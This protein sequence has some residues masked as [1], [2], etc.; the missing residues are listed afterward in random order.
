MS[1][2]PAE[3]YQLESLHSAEVDAGKPP[4]PSPSTASIDPSQVRWLENQRSRKWEVCKIMFRACGTLFSAIVLGICLA[5]YSYRPN[6]VLDVWPGILLFGAVP[7]FFWDL[8]EFLTLCARYGRGITP[9]ALIGLELVLSVVSAVAAGYV[10]LQLSWL[11]GDPA[12]NPVNLALCACVLTGINATNTLSRFI[13]FCLFIRACIERSREIRRRRPR[14]MYI[15]ETGQTVYVVAKP[16]PKLPTWQSQNSARAPSFP[17]SPVQPSSPLGTTEPVTSTFPDFT[18]SPRPDTPPPPLP[19]RPGHQHALPSAIKRKPV[20][21]LPPRTT[22]GDRDRH[23]RPSMR[24][25]PD[26]YVPDEAE[27]ERMRRGD[28]QPQLIL[29]G[30]VDLKFATGAN[31]MTPAAGDS[32]EGKF[33]LNKNLVLGESSRGGAGGARTRSI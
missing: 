27:L 9:K 18:E 24:P 26:D 29:P 19:E 10:G 7:S 2:A 22:P 31:G 8:A 21:G 3:S 32:R 17:R 1:S 4:S 11:D 20:R 28:A 13:R 15:P 12:N 33:R 16:F 14:V 6:Y 23:L 25:P 30:D 5:W